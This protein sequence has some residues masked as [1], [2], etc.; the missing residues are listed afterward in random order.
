VPSGKL[1]KR[2]AAPRE[3]GQARIAEYAAAATADG[4]EIKQRH[5]QHHREPNG[6]SRHIACE[7]PDRQE[8][9]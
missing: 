2:E 5:A 7:K 3:R 8:A 9:H 6:A 1:N 4:V